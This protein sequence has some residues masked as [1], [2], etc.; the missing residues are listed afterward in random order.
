MSEP[1]LE[2]SGLKVHFPIKRGLV[3]DRT[4]GHVRAVDGVDLQVR[5][6]QTFG[7]VGESG[8]GKSTLGRAILRL[9]EPTDGQVRFDGEDLRDLGPEPLR[10]MRRRMQMVFQD[11]LSSLD[12]RASVESLLTEPLTVHGLAEADR[13]EFGRDSAR[14]HAAK[15]SS[16]LDVVGLPGSALAKYPHEF[17]GG[18]RQRIGIARAMILN[19]DLVIADEPVSALD[20]SVQA[21]VINLLEGLQDLLGLTYLVIAHDLA[22]VRHISDVIG[23]MYLGT[24]VEQ[25]DS[26]DLYA[27]PLHPYTIALMSAI[28]IPD[29]DVE[30]RR[31]RILLRGDLPSPANPPSGCRFHT[32]CPYRQPT[33]CDTEVPALRAVEGTEG[34]LVACHWAEDIRSGAVHVADPTLLVEPDVP[35]PVAGARG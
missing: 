18:Q 22:V 5:R 19:P 28:P 4:V 29:P 32:R 20:V 6:G 16:M 27:E 2:V 7:L 3:F 21:Q 26:D 31:E 24:I 30:D 11:P 9:E 17:S 14:S 15:A 23:V 25:A 10:K 33:R 8:C 12:P 13:Q 35:V 1:L 34:R